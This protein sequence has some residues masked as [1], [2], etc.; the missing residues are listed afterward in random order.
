MKF[1]LVL[2]LLFSFN[3]FSQRYIAF[4]EKTAP[5]APDYAD[6]ANW[7]ALPF[8]KDAAD[9]IPKSE[10]WVN[11]SLKEVD[12]FYVHPTLYRKGKTWNADVKNRKLNNK[13]DQK[14]V[15][16]QASA[17][18]A[19]CRVYAPRYRQAIIDVFYEEKS[20]PE[21]S[22]KALDLAYQDVRKAF[23]F[24]LLN[25]NNGRP[26]IIAGHSQ[27]SL[28]A[29]RLLQEFIDTTKLRQRMIAAYIVGMAVHEN[30][31]KNLRI[32]ESADATNCFV[33]WIS[34]KEG[35]LPTSKFFAGSQ[36]VN[37]V[38]WT[39]DTAF[40]D[41]GNSLGTVVLNI[42][43]KR[44][45]CCNT[46]LTGDGDVLWVKTKAPL[47]RR[48]KNLHIADYNLFWYDIRKNVRVR[49]EAWKPKV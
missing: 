40:V 6:K 10:T 19:S 37:P 24:Y 30:M 45:E 16:F 15:H 5:A 23:E 26:F 27:G 18:N 1:S 47:L 14:P 32:C 39:T 9:V 21:D 8:R 49:I 36:C 38:T 7:S 43:K 48:F 28:H 41:R 44:A 17:F 46:R 31:Y 34:Y 33:G 4:D 20:T 13:V 29:R 25:Y 22:R 35:H 42:N 3:A 11:D 2:M 12:V